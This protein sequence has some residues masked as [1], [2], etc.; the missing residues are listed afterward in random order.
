MRVLEVEVVERAINVRRDRGGKVGAK[1]LLVRVVRDI[2]ETLRM[3][4]PEVALVRWAEVDLVLAQ[5]RFDPV[6]EHAR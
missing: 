5:R 1:L 3:R 4:I 6:G 2:D